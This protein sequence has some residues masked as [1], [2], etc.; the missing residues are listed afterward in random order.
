MA[1]VKI[2]LICL[3]IVLKITNAST[4]S[5]VEN[6]E[7]INNIV[8]V[9][10]PHVLSIIKTESLEPLSLTELNGGE[11]SNCIL[12]GL[13]SIYR[14]GNCTLRHQ[15]SSSLV[16]HLRIGFQRLIGSC[17]ISKR[18]IIFRYSGLIRMRMDDVA[19]AIVIKQDGDSLLAENS[20][21]RLVSLDL[22]LE[23]GLNIQTE[24]DATLTFVLDTLK[25]IYIRR[26]ERVVQHNLKEYFTSYLNDYLSNINSWNEIHPAIINSTN[27]N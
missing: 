20:R 22:A 2:L 9:I 16:I 19:S 26:L 10:L 17:A 14:W 23:K 5:E 8:D 7:N 21:P 24:G 15:L 4:Q 27:L 12:S 6:E 13:S 11:L 1:A 25:V 18:V 3:L